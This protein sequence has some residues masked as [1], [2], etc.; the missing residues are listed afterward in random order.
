MATLTVNGTA[1][2]TVDGKL[3]KKSATY[4]A[5]VRSL[6]EGTK[7]LSDTYSVISA[8]GFT[9]ALIE[10]V[11]DDSIIV[12]MNGVGS[13]YVRYGIPPGGHAFIQGRTGTAASGMAVSKVLV[14][15]SVT[16]AGSRIVFTIGGNWTNE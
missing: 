3:V 15:R 10:N 8:Q 16:S 2:V 4:L 13:D 1:S 11:G 14:A 6:L 9:F 5:D 7:D 12:R